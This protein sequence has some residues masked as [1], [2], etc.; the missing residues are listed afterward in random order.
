L[1]GNS[2]PGAPKFT[3]SISADYTLPVS[4]DWAATVHGDFYWQDR[5][6][7]RVENDDPYDRIR[8][9]TNVNLAL[10][11]SSQNGWQV[12]G[13]LKNVFNTTAITGDFLNS[14]DTG[15]TTNVFLTDP[16]L[17]GLRITKNW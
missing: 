1:S 6:W 14:D 3:T 17:Y 12:M 2:L 7:A 16:R 5:S 11:L 8:G 10:I 9:Y 13:Y 15:L 4:A